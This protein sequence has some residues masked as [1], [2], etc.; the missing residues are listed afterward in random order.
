MT[1]KIAAGDYLTYA[2][3]APDDRLKIVQVRR[4]QDDWVRVAA[5]A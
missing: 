5:A 4:A 2:N 3:C 1:R